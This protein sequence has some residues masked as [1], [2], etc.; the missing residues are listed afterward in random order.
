MVYDGYK[1][2]ITN[3]L[4]FYKPVISEFTNNLTFRETMTIVG[5]HFDSRPEKNIV[6]FGNINATVLIANRK[7]LTVK[8]PDN[9]ASAQSN[10][11]VFCNTQ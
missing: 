2:T 1:D 11:S 7:E 8:V 4:K 10:I 9:L 6:R 3:D 5:D